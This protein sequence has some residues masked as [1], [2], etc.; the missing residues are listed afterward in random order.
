MSDVEGLQRAYART[1]GVYIRTNTMFVAG[2]KDFP[3]D[4]WDDVSK[5]P[6]QAITNSLRY[7]NADKA[8]N[9]NDALYPNHEITSLVGHSLAGSVVL[10]MQKQYPDINFITTTFGAPVASMTAPHGTNNKRY[11]NDDD[12]TSMIDRGSIMTVKEPVNYSSNILDIGNIMFNNHRHIKFTNQQIDNT[13]QD[14]YVCE[15]DE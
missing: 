12:P 4:H 5:I 13:S 7:M 8:L 11:R 2:T 1:N 15:T 6:F 10:E 3:Q 9:Q 14:T